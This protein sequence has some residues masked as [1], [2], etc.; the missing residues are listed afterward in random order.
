MRL[1]EDRGIGVLIYWMWWSVS[2]IL[3][4]WTGVEFQNKF[5]KGAGY[6]FATYPLT[7]IIQSKEGDKTEYS[8][9]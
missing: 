7:E 6:R 2:C 4:D 3:S 8:K 5:F 9:S 1:E